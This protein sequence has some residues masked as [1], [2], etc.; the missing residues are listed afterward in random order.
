MSSVDDD[1][2]DNVDEDDLC[3]VEALITQNNLEKGEKVSF[4]KQEASW[5]ILEQTKEGKIMSVEKVVSPNRAIK[6]QIKFMA[7][8]VGKYEFDLLEKSETY[9][10][11]MPETQENS[12][13]HEK[14]IL[15]DDADELEDEPTIFEELLSAPHIR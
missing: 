9:K 11:G 15:P 14:K 12:V 2:D 10:V 8:P 3:S 7:P 13:L 6:H 1:E 5:I 4:P